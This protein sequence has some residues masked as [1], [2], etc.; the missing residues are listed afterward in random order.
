MKTCILVDKHINEY[1]VAK[2]IEI[3]TYYSFLREDIPWTKTNKWLQIH[4]TQT[5]TI[6]RYLTVGNW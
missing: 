6:W 4:D 3:S 2:N 5:V 1:T